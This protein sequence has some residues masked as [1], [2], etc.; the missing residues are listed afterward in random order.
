M[1][2][3]FEYNCFTVLAEWFYNNK[4]I[5]FVH[6][7]FMVMFLMMTTELQGSKV[8]TDLKLQQKIPILPRSNQCRISG[9]SSKQ[10]ALKFVTKRPGKTNK[11]MSRYPIIIA[12]LFSAEWF[13]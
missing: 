8:V 7:D 13:R 12:S 6:H 10:Y 2:R 4:I 11:R 3:P 9:L 5:Y 1:S